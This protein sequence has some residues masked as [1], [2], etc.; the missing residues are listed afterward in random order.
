MRPL[1]GLTQYLDPSSVV[2]GRGIAG[3]V[4]LGSR[5]FH[6]DCV[7][8]MSKFHM[9]S[10]SP[11]RS[12]L[13]LKAMGSECGFFK[14]RVCDTSC[15]KGPS[16][17]SMF[18]GS[19]PRTKLTLETKLYGVELDGHGGRVWVAG[20]GWWSCLP[21]LVIGSAVTGYLGRVATNLGNQGKRDGRV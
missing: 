5:C 12:V 3:V 10:R 19:M 20:M 6:L 11:Q 21:G 18:V 13:T 1:F 17:L 7:S 8:C 15:W 4:L 2:V 16:H 14:R 9:T